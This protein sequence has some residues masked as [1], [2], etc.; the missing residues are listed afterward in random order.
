MIEKCTKVTEKNCKRIT[1]FTI[2]FHAN[3]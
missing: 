3:S 2:T 1:L